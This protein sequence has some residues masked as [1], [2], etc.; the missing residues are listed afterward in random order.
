MH[1]RQ[2]GTAQADID[3]LFETRNTA[4]KDYEQEKQQEEKWIN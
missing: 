1:A 4:L 3:Q 2:R